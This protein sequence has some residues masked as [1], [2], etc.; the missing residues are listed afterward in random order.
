MQDCRGRYN[1]QGTFTKYLHE[2]EDGYDTLSWLLKQPWCNGRIG[3]MGLSYG[4]HTQCAL[5]CLN[6]P[7]LACM[8]MD[9]GG[10]SSAYHGGI[11]RGGAFELKQATW[12][13]KHALLSPDTARNPDRQ[14]ALKAEDITAWFKDMPWRPG[15]S[16]LRHAPEYESYLF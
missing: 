10:F 2:A 16:P 14:K 7:G 3:T 4:A 5:S 12:A 11:R 13:Y 9:S 8:F 6:P 15:H 1:S